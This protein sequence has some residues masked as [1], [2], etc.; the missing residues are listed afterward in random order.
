MQGS[1]MD[2]IVVDVILTEDQAEA[3]AEM[4]KRFSRDDA[5]RL[6]ADEVEE[7]SMIEGVNALSKALANAGFNPR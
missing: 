6:S 2:E 5:K 4:A 3:L 1:E 7:Q